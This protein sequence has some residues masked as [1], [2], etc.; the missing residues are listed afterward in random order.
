MSP[1][2][3]TLWKTSVGVFKNEEDAMLKKNRKKECYDRL[4]PAEYEEPQQIFAMRIYDV[5][6]EP[7]Y[8]E[9]NKLEVK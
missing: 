3:V 6:G 9:M 7:H 4:G 2:V 8:F 5:C 1:E